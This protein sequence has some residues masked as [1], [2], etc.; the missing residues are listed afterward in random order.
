MLSFRDHRRDP[1]AWAR[2][3]AISREAIEIYLAADV[4][5]LHVD[6]FIWTRSWGYRLDK[7]HGHGLFGARLYSQVDL[8]RIREAQIGGAV[9]SITTNPL[10][11][12]AS[13]ARTFDDNFDD[14]RAIFDAQRADIAPCRDVRDYRAARAAG[15][16]AAFVGIQGGNALDAEGALEHAIARCD[17]LLQRVTLVHLSTSALGVTS[18]PSGGDG[19]LTARGQAYV[20]QLDA[21][22]IFVDLAHVNRTGFFDAAAAHDPS[23]PLL[24]SHTGVT[25]VTPHWRNVDD[26]QLRAIAATGGV[27][28]I[29][30]QS[31]FLG[32]PLL[33]GRCESIAEH[34][35]HVVDTIGDDH[36]ALGSDWDG[37]IFTPRDMPTCLELPRLVERLLARGWSAERIHKILGGNYLRALAQLRP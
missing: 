7:R 12:A 30:F 10:R 8:P 19:H 22:R 26:E 25:G 13:R 23:L 15:K 20:R 36:A 14:L 33:A 35:Q 6:S 29:M 3:L 5:D 24:V 2:E 27:V 4:I 11:R 28:G 1:S 37:A 31:T 32:D 34:L 9:W 16:H 18:A 21:A 17:G